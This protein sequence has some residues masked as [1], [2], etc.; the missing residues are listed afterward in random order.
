MNTQH[1]QLHKT[2][3]CFLSSVSPEEAM[4][5]GESFDKLLSQK[6]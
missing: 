5:W 3:F 6:G 1:A 4:K 2:V